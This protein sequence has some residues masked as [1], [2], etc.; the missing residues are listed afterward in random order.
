MKLFMDVHHFGPGKVD[1]EAVAE[2]HKKDLASQAKHNAKYLNYWF[3]A[4]S[5]TVMCLS[6]AP[7]A[8]DALAVHKDAHGLMPESI[9]E[10]S[11]GR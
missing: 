8:E 1:A 3:D 2:A 11:E 5:G 6:E 7:S 9:E 4:A 10:V